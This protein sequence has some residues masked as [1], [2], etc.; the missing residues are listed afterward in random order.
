MHLRFYAIPCVFFKCLL[1]PS[2]VLGVITVAQHSW[3]N[4]HGI[5]TDR[6]IRHD[7]LWLR[8][9]RDILQIKTYL[10]ILYFA[11]K[12]FISFSVR[13]WLV[14]FHSEVTDWTVISRRV[15]L[16][17]FFKNTDLKSRF[18]SFEIL[19]LTTFIT[20]FEDIQFHSS[21]KMDWFLY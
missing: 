15:K 10:R 2:F 8:Q 19:F 5:M 16:E 13:P 9:T 12:K 1:R 14:I 4:L 6:F 11:F 21:V 7:K 20:Q 3:Q 18:T 17:T